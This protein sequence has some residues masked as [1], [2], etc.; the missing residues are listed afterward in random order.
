MSEPGGRGMPKDFEALVDELKAL[1]EA[2]EEAAKIVENAERD[3]EKMIREAEEQSANIMSETEEDIRKAS[4]ELRQD[5]HADTRS[6][7]D[8]LEKNYATDIKRIKNKASKNMEEAVAYVV[9]QALET[10]TETKGGS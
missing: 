1:K 7:A 3:A 2:E 4:R 5:A 6:E 8:S 10:K 9:N